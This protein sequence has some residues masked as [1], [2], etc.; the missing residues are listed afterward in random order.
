MLFRFTVILCGL[1]VSTAVNGQSWHTPCGNSG[2][3]WD[4]MLTERLLQNIQ[5]LRD[6]PAD[7]E[8]R[9]IVYV[10]IRFHMVA[11]T[12][13]A[14]RVTYG[15]VL[16][17]LCRLNQDFDSLNMQFYIKALNDNINNTAIYQTQ[18]SAGTVMNLLRDNTAMNIWIVDLAAGSPPGPND[19]PGVTLGYYSPQ[20]DWIVIRRDQANLSS[21][22]LP[23]EVGHFFSL[24]HTHNGWDA[25]P[26]NP[27]VHGS[28][29][30]SISP[31]NVPTERQDGSNCQ[32][33]GDFICDT[34]PD[35]NGLGHTGCN[36]TALDPTGTPINPDE[37]LFMSYFDGCVRDQYYFSNTQKNLIAADY[38]SASR[39]YLRPN[40]TPNTT[41]ITQAPTLTFPINNE[42]TPGFNQVNFQWTGV[43]GADFYL[44]EID[45][46]SNFT[47]NP[48]RIIVPGA[49]SH[50]VTT[51]LANRTYFWRVRPY[52][53]YRT[54][55]PFTPAAQF[56]TNNVMVSV[57]EIEE[58]GEW[59]V[60]PNPIGAERRLFIRLNTLQHFNGSLRLHNATGQ[61]VKHVGQQYVP[62]GES[63]LE[64]D[65]ANLPR[66]LYVLT[67]E[68]RQGREQRRIVIAE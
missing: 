3:E 7:V 22:T 23:H 30:P 4:I 66:G 28:P 51:L 49:T 43:A 36:Y 15:Q 65:L 25:Q 14:G 52:N 18:Y 42:F 35:Y 20:R 31:G 45:L 13:G 57:P 48:I 59:T 39:N 5:T 50:T 61:V 64:I 19:P 68:H 37:Q 47:N 10:P 40:I 12:N 1:L 34:P 26:Y 32:T 24:K 53:A 33:A 62:A 67:I 17:V 8:F 16:D 6:N 46:A 38:N 56:R 58:L 44:L 2:G 21:T 9:N 55:A 63:M 54:C 41:Q 60:S 11:N 27:S 29:A